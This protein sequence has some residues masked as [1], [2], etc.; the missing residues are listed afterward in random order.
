MYTKYS[1]PTRASGASDDDGGH[2]HDRANDHVHAIVLPVEKVESLRPIV[3]ER[4]HPPLRNILPS[5][6]GPKHRPLAK[7]DNRS[8]LWKWNL[9]PN[10]DQ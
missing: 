10:L 1:V 3:A 5:G 4:D 2:D 8:T 7:Q 6:L 9:G